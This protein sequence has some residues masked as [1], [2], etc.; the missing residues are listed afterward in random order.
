MACLFI[1]LLQKGKGGK[2]LTK[3]KKTTIEGKSV[4]NDVEIAGFRASIDSDNPDDMTISV[5]QSNK[6]EYK[7]N[8]VAARADQAEFEDYAYTVQDELK[9]EMQ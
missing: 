5:W 8:R 9:T 1:K 4:V 6:A 2:M 3:K 7:A